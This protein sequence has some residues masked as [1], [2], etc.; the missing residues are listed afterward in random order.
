M[1]LISDSIR[2]VPHFPKEGIMFQDVTTIF[3]NPE[4]FKNCIDLFTERYQGKGVDVVAGGQDELRLVRRH[5]LDVAE[6]R[7]SLHA[8]L[9]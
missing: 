6:C 2:T 4:A 8:K 3:L 5:C 9:Y 7:H 1:A